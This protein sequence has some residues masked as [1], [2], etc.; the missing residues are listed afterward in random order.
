MDQLLVLGF[1]NKNA[2][3]FTALADTLSQTASTCNPQA[4]RNK[5]LN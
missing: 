3:G 5:Y 1:F 2:E 4:G